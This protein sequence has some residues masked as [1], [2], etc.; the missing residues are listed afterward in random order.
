MI[1]WGLS[2]SL[3]SGFGWNQ[4][5]IRILCCPSHCLGVGIK[6]LQVWKNIYTLSYQHPQWCQTLQLAWMLKRVQDYHQKVIIHYFVSSSHHSLIQYSE[7]NIFS[8]Q[9]NSKFDLMCE[10]YCRIKQCLCKF[11]RPRFIAYS[12]FL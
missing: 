4:P 8:F 9:H 2:L 7:S 6:W 12:P 10:I 3:K 1:C 11:E 5:I